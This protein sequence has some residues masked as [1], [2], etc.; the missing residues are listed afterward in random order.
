M[1]ALDEYILM[2]LFVVLQ[3]SSFSSKLKLKVWPLKWKL[4]M[5]SNG[6]VRDITEESSFSST[7]WAEKRSSE[8]GYT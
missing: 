8:K 1:K 5:N 4:W 6:T 7:T 2:V 3:K